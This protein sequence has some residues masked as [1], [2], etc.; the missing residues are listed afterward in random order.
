[1]SPFIVTTTRP[2]RPPTRESHTV[3]G[4]RTRVAVATLEEAQRIVNTALQD[5]GNLQREAG[6]VM[7]GQRKTAVVGA[8][9]AVYDDLVERGI[10]APTPTVQMSA[11]RVLADESIVARRALTYDVPSESEPGRVH[12]VALYLRL[13]RDRVSEDAVAPARVPGPGG[14]A[15][16]GLRRPVL[17]P[18]PRR[19]PE[20]RRRERGRREPPA[21]PRA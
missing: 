18:Q 4:A 5:A 9:T 21:G 7:D 15:Q 3:H 20:P 8:V 2:A 14:L 16:R 6:P 17:V 10:S 12:V 1:M 11:M 13:R 19:D